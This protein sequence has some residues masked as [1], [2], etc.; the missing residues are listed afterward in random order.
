[1]NIDTSWQPRPR[2]LPS[3]GG[4]RNQGSGK[5]TDWFSTDFRSALQKNAGTV[6]REGGG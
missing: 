5:H 1:M 4:A 3:K 6:E 2:P